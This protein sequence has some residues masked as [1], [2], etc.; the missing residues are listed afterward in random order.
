MAHN[1]YQ[2]SLHQNKSN[3]SPF[4]SYPSSQNLPDFASFTSHESSKT[5]SYNNA[6]NL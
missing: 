6:S 5:L 1:N 2:K 4:N 3:P